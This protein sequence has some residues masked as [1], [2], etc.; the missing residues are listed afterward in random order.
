M[1]E[2]DLTGLLTV[3]EAIRI[4][5]AAPVQ[6]RIVELDLEAAQGLC[7]A[8]EVTTDRDYPPF[9]K[10]LMDGFAVRVGDLEQLPAELRVVGEIAAGRE[11]A[12]PLRAGQ[13][14]AIMTGAPLPAGADGV[15]PVEEAEYREPEPGAGQAT[16]RVAKAGAW[17]RWVAKQG[18][19]VK[20]GQ[21]VLHKGMRLG[22]AQLGLAAM[23]GAS[24]V[25]VFAAPR[26]AVLA[27]G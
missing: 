3:E 25:R 26:V 15:V 19:D 17:G 9:D 1:G 12:E 27:T 4:I 16:I 5:D 7:L 22:A 24:R 20:A 10:S 8:E 18:S 14:M 23:V 11:A 13:A 21:V 2:L 6:P